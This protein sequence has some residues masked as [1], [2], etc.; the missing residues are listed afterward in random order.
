MQ[1]F[2][3]VKLENASLGFP[4]ADHVPEAIPTRDVSECGPTLPPVHNNA[5]VQPC[6]AP[7]TKF[8]STETIGSDLACDGPA[9]TSD[10]PSAQNIPVMDE[11]GLVAGSF[12][13]AELNLA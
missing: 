5:A 8:V 3:Y 7:G 11:I 2:K 12:G 6:E 10:A 1:K 9:G 13:G 4:S